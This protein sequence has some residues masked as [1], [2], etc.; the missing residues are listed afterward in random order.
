MRTGVTGNG[1]AGRN[2]LQEIPEY[3]HYCV[4]TV[5]YGALDILPFASTDFANEFYF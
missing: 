2:G 3:V 5:C 1:S 4:T